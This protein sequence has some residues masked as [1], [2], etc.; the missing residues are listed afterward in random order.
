MTKPLKLCSI[1]VM[2]PPSPRL[3]LSCPEAPSPLN[4]RSVADGAQLE[5]IHRH[6]RVLPVFHGVQHLGGCVK[7]HSRAVHACL[8]ALDC[9]HVP[10][11]CVCMRCQDA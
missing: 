3:A 7:R 8:F 5:W 9:V 11:V 4:F 6:A 10:Q 2:R 1:I